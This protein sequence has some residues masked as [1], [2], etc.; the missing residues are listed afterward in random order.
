MR[1]IKEMVHI[2]PFEQI[3]TVAQTI[4]SPH[5]HHLGIFPPL[6]PAAVMMVSA[7]Q[8]GTLKHSPIFPELYNFKF[9][10]FLC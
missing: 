5:Q 7:Q 6:I 8:I 2:Y 3:S 1:K 4:R 9:L 10:R